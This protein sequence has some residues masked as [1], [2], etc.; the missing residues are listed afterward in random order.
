MLRVTANDGFHSTA[1]V[2]D[3]FTSIG[4]KPTV[5]ILEPTARAV[6]TQ[7]GTLLLQAA[8]YDDAGR[9]LDGK[10]VVWSDGRRRLGRGAALS[11]DD[12]QPGRRDA[13]RH[14]PRRPRP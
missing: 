3:V 11:V 8:A 7:G 1:A 9:R 6:V 14:R 10:S 12:L 13:A 4:R 2:S 5:T